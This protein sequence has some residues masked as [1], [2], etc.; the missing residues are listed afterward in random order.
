MVVPWPPPPQSPLSLGKFLMGWFNFPLFTL[1]SGFYLLHVMQRLYSML[2]TMPPRLGPLDAQCMVFYSWY[3]SFNWFTPLVLW[4]RSWPIDD[5]DF[6]IHSPAD[7]L[8]WHIIFSPHNFFPLSLITLNHLFPWS[9]GRPIVLEHVFS[10]PRPTSVLYPFYTPCCCRALGACSSHGTKHC[11][12]LFPWADQWFFVFFPC[13]H[14]QYVAMELPAPPIGSSVRLFHASHLYLA[15]DM[16]SPLFHFTPFAK[17]HFLALPMT[18]L[19]PSHGH[20]EGFF[21]CFLFAFFFFWVFLFPNALLCIC[22]Y[23]NPFL[24][25]ILHVPF[26]GITLLPSFPHFSFFWPTN[27]RGC[28]PGMCFVQKKRSAYHV[29]LFTPH[30]LP[31]LPPFFSLWPFFPCPPGP[32]QQYHGKFLPVDI[33]FAVISLKFNDSCKP[34]SPFAWPPSVYGPQFTF[35]HHGPCATVSARSFT[36]TTPLVFIVVVPPLFAFFLPN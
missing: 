36:T 35:L 21:F 25:L 16:F 28:S 22:D 10:S 17:S 6:L 33:P 12:G 31:K 15:L 5:D 32:V 13:L 2:L 24:L 19:H 4:P 26:H 27:S 23:Q 30:M 34:I 11:T 18:L 29:L 3:R 7:L 8:W 14:F 20:L 1:T 9:L